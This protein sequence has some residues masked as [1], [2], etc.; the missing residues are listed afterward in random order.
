MINPKVTIP[1]T[2]ILMGCAIMFVTSMPSSLKPIIK[3]PQPPHFDEICIIKRECQ[4]SIVMD[5]FYLLRLVEQQSPFGETMCR[6][7]ING[8][9]RWYASQHLS[10]DVLCFDLKNKLRMTYLAINVDNYEC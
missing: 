3:I 4:K 10:A 7:N 1:L 6:L 9:L 8:W 2:S 5:V